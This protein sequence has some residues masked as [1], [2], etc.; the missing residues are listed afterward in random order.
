VHWGYFPGD[1]ADKAAY[2]EA[3]N[4]WSYTS[5]SQNVFMVWIEKER[6]NFNFTFTVML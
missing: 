5:T 4:E 3:K 2:H 1:I 6:E